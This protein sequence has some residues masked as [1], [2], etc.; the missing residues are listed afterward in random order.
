MLRVQQLVGHGGACDWSNTWTPLFSSRKLYKVACS[1][2][3]TPPCWHTAQLPQRPLRSADTSASVSSPRPG[4][5]TYPTYDPQLCPTCFGF[6]FFPRGR[7]GRR[8]GGQFHHSPVF[9]EARAPTLSFFFFYSETCSHFL[10][11]SA[12]TRAG[13]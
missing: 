2:N 5:Q 6:S 9:S 12:G 8:G 1:W 7:E 11:V 10:T 3:R 13:D 4:I